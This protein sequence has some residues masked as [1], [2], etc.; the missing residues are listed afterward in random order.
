ML[1]NVQVWYLPCR[2]RY[3]SGASDERSRWSFPHQPPLTPEEM[4]SIRLLYTGLKGREFCVFLWVAACRIE[5]K[6][7]CTSCIIFQSFRLASLLQCPC[8]ARFE[9]SAA[10][11][12][13]SEKMVQLANVACTAIWSCLQLSAFSMCASISAHALLRVCLP[14]RCCSM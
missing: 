14:L 1:W 13:R 10:T 12:G 5:N 11:A 8:C 4:D 9:V 6:K 2:R 3:N 7:N